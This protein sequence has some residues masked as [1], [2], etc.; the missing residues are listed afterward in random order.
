MEEEERETCY[1][2]RFLAYNYLL[3]FFF[4][5][6]IDRLNEGRKYENE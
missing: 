2:F 4:V 5:L 3:G 1:Y 6:E